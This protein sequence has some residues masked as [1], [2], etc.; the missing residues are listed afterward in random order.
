MY[1]VT[2]VHTRPNI[3]TAF[4]RRGN[5]V[6][7]KA[8]DAKLNG[9]LLSEESSLSDDKLTVTYIAV[10]DSFASFD[11]FSKE[12][13]VVEFRNAKNEHNRTTGIMQIVNK[14]ENI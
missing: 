7:E 4:H 10:W 1:K 12:A 13:D 6:I 3:E 11:A 9:K 5:E 8:T 2:M 14:Q